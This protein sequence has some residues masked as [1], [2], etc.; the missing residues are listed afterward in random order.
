MAPLTDNNPGVA[1][2]ESRRGHGFRYDHGRS[3]SDASGCRRSAGHASDQRIACRWA[4]RRARRHRQR[5]RPHSPERDRYRAPSR[6]LARAGVRGRTGGGETQAAH[7]RG[8]RCDDARRRRSKPRYAAARYCGAAGEERHQAGADR[9]RR[10]AGRHD[11]PCQP[12]PG[13]GDQAQGAQG[14]N[15]HQRSDDSED[16]TSRLEAR[17]GANRSRINAVVH[18]GIVELW[19][20]VRSGTEKDV[21]RRLAERTPGVRTVNDHLVVDPGPSSPQAFSAHVA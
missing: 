16:V 1:T 18:D 19:G 20:V 8:R 21:I 6:L 4:R 12:G 10:E 13:A 7:P 17:S 15:R 5:W 14:R 11:H 2:H 3:G 9:E